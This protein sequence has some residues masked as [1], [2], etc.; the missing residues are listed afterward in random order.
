[1]QG[2]VLALAALLLGWSPVQAATLLPETSPSPTAAPSAAPEIE[3]RQEAGSDQAVSQRIS[4]IFSE[5]PALAG[6]RANV[7]E[8]VVTL[9][10][11]VT[12]AEDKAR[13][14]VIASRISGVV[15]VE[16]QI[17]RDVSVGSRLGVLGTFS[18]Q[19]TTLVAA[20]PLI[21]VAVLAAL[22][23]AGL[24]YAIASLE[25][26]WRRVTPNS[27]LAELIASA[28]RFAFI[29]AG[30]LV[31]LNILGAGTLLGAVLG[32]AG[33]V[34]IALGFSLR[35]IIENYVASVMLSLRQPFRP[36]E[37]VKIEDYEGRII[38]LT[39]RA[40]L[41]MT[42]DG[43]HVR[44]PNSTVFKGVIVNYT[45][46]PQRSFAFEIGIGVNEDAS[47]AGA[48]GVAALRGLDFVLPEPAPLF[49][50]QEA[51]ASS[52]VLKFIA[53][54]DQGET[55]WFKARS[56]ALVTVKNALDADEV[57]MPEP[58]YRLRFDP[59]SPL[60]IKDMEGAEEAAP[61][62]DRRRGSKGRARPVDQ[63]VR[64]ENEVAKMV[65]E[66]RQATPGKGDLLNPNRPVE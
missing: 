40:T 41:L 33:V 44:I 1:M 66:E 46:N 32:G 30:A 51:A 56:Q 15:T 59:E 22:L 27:F 58:I 43:N 57:E 29:V 48:T 24:G 5:I 11:T 19:L 54:I 28:I 36:N 61:P 50:V 62:P 38:R 39:S 53:W 26:L 25:S 8:G 34:G 17:E 13:A 60:P 16:N 42:L 45:R 64:P 10:G 9:T 6:V 23:I 49:L 12:D 35:D 21:A 37:L 14:E 47:V 52:V 18:E 65:E 4:S 2:I 55:N 20:L 7:R 31:A 3:A 63:D